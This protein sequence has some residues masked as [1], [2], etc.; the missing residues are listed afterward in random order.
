M[1]RCDKMHPDSPRIERPIIKV[2]LLIG[3]RDL[4]LLSSILKLSGERLQ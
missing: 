4:G 1:N 3:E 2:A